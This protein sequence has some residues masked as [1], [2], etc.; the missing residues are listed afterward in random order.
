M[1][2][3]YFLGLINLQFQWTFGEI[4]FASCCKPYKYVSLPTTR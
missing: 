2:D 4:N 1:A 3:K